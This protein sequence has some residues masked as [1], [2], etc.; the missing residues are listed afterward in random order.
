MTEKSH[1]SYVVRWVPRQLGYLV[2][3]GPYNMW[4]DWI[5]DA[6]EV[7]NFL[8][9]GRDCNHGACWMVMGLHGWKADGSCTTPSWLHFMCS[10]QSSNDCLKPSNSIAA[11][12]QDPLHTNQALLK[13]AVVLRVANHSRYSRRNVAHTAST[14]TLGCG[15]SQVCS[16]H[17]WQLPAHPVRYANYW[18][19][20]W[21]LI[22]L[23]WVQ[24]VKS[25]D[26]S[27]RQ[28]VGLEIGHGE[29]IKAAI[30]AKVSTPANCISCG[31]LHTTPRYT[32]NI[33]L[34]FVRSLVIF[35]NQ[36]RMPCYLTTG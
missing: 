31:Q 14:G 17:W 20:P 29:H 10:P 2:Q 9:L 22:I 11:H 23:P 16:I 36:W 1:L 21:Y 4:A 3:T 18:E 7:P 24:K 8:F 25:S 34:M 26:S 27:S 32:M 19:S 33:S 28:C 13:G 12:L 35:V 30:W 5:R 15:L 6:M